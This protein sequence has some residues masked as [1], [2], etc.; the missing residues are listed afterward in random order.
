MLNTASLVVAPLG[1]FDASIDPAA[2]NAQRN[3]SPSAASLTAW[4]TC[5]SRRRMS[6]PA[7]QV[8]RGGRC[9]LN[10]AVARHDSTLSSALGHLEHSS[11]A[12]RLAA[13]L[14]GGPVARQRSATRHQ[15]LDC[16]LGEAPFRC[17]EPPLS[18]VHAAAHRRGSCGA[19]N[20]RPR[21]SQRRPTPCGSARPALLHHRPRVSR[22]A[23]RHRIHLSRSLGSHSLRARHLDRKL[24]S[25]PGRPDAAATRK[26]GDDPIS[27]LRLND[28][29]ER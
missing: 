12:V 4:P 10:P 21:P 17:I 18:I 28:R 13:I 3:R 19:S 20:F 29:M 1:F 23:G 11:S 16:T 22:R 9:R 5:C 26:L 25:L 8:R 2:R 7:R 15:N 27:C 14:I 6:S 24:V